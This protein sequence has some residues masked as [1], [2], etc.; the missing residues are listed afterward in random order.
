M[1]DYQGTTFIHYLSD[2]DTERALE[3]GGFNYTVS[4]DTSA[5]G[6]AKMHWKDTRAV[7]NKTDTA[8]GWQDNGATD[9]RVVIQDFCLDSAS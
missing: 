5:A 1:Q 9:C 8:D 6:S 3:T 2:S 7:E 4:I